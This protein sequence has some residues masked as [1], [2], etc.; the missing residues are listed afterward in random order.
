M[1]PLIFAEAGRLVHVARVTGQPDVRKH[2]SD[3][4][5]VE[6]ESIQVVSQRDGDVI[7]IVKGTRFAITSQ[8]ASK[9]LVN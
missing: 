3:L 4:G 9:I 8:M 2:L 1:M 5:F 6:G 7:V